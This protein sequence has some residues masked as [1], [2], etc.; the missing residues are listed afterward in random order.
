[1]IRD[2]NEKQCPHEHFDDKIKQRNISTKNKKKKNFKT[3]F[4]IQN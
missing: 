2:A 3:E 4:L 1:M